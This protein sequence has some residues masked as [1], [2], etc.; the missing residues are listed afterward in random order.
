MRSSHGEKKEGENNHTIFPLESEKQKIPGIW[1]PV[2]EDVRKTCISHSLC[3]SLVQMVTPCSTVGF[4]VVWSNKDQGD[5]P[6]DL[7]LALDHLNRPSKLQFESKKTWKFSTEGEQE[8]FFHPAMKGSACRHS[9]KTLGNCFCFLLVPTW[10]FFPAYIPTQKWWHKYLATVLCPDEHR[11]E[12]VFRLQG[13]KRRRT[14]WES[15]VQRKQE[16]CESGPGRGHF[17]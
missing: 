9:T 3:V 6:T 4:C 10:A 15:K 17:F 12:I 5:G 14:R 16:S 7:V 1:G 11:T 8:A 2:S 13:R